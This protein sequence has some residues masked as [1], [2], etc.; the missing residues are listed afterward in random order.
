MNRGQAELPA[1][2]YLGLVLVPMVVQIAAR[3][4]IPDDSVY[5]PI[6]NGEMGVI[7]LGTLMLLLIAVVLIGREAIRQHRRGETATA[8]LLAFIAAGAFLFMAEEAS[9]G[10]WFFRWNS[11]GWFLE[12]NLQGETNLHNLGFVK[13]NIAKWGVVAAILVF[14]IV[15]ALRRPPRSG[16][17]GPFD[18]RVMPSIASVPAAVV[19][20]VTH[21]GAKLLFLFWQ[22]NDEEL[23]GIDIREATEFYVAMFGMIYALSLR[24]RFAAE[25]TPP[26]SRSEPTGFS[27][28]RHYP[29]HPAE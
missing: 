27:D 25:D 15:L 21:L 1:T 14:G 10:Q 26:A 29:A 19:V 17:I 8:L 3:I 20:V 24:R 12:N 6:F 2:L 16:R 13:K 4:L 28:R 23:T 7:E 22:L 11:P 5:E 18:A 9:W